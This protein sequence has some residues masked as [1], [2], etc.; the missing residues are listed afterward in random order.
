MQEKQRFNYAKQSRPCFNCLQPYTKNHIC[1]LHVCR[2]CHNRHHTL[3]HMARQTQVVNDRS[4]ISQSAGS[5]DNP[6][7]EVNRYCSFKG[8]SRNHILLATAIVEIQK[9]LVSTFHAE[10]CWTV[11]LSHISSQRDVYNV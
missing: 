10:H 5:Q 2:K 3:L 1:S 8:K 11:L 7:A 4:P 6:T 9:K